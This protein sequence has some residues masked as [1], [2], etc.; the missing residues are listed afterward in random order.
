MTYLEPL[1]IFAPRLDGESLITI[2]TATPLRGRLS[3]ELRSPVASYLRAG[4]ILFAIMEYTDDVLEQRF[5]VSGGSAVLSDGRYYWRLDAADYV[6]TYGLAVPE[7]ALDH[8]RLRGWKP[9]VFE[10]D[11]YDQLYDRLHAQL[12]RLARDRDVR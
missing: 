10:G 6:E 5:G 7:D 9:P 11:A 2:E 12:A 1:G 3:P 4:A 8:M